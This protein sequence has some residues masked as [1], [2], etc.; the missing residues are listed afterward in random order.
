M[1]YCANCGVKLPS[2]ALFCGNCGQSQNRKKYMQA[3]TTRQRSSNIGSDYINYFMANLKNPGSM[4]KN[5][6]YSSLINILVLSLMFVLM[7]YA[8]AKASMRVVERA[9][10]IFGARSG[11]GYDVGINDVVKELFGTNS[12]FS[13]LEVTF[14]IILIV[15]L[16]ISALIGVTFLIKRYAL[17][18]P[19]KY[20]RLLCR[21]ASYLSFPIAIMAIVSLAAI[22]GIAGPVLIS[23]CFYYILSYLWMLFNVLLMDDIHKNKGPR[24]QVYWIGS[25]PVFLGIALFLIV[26]LIV[27]GLA[28]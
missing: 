28:G 1:K 6:L 14:S 8:F 10:N 26:G 9:A 25:M 13:P 15:V 11:L 23:I 4:M 22:I 12:L 20:V 2:N 19:T 24:Y 18:R 5:N 27:G 3:S 16:I 7:L 17:N 21:Y